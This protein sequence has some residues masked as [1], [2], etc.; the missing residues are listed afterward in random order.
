[1]K[2][3]FCNTPYKECDFPTSCEFTKKCTYSPLGV[4]LMEKKNGS[5]EFYKLLEDMAA[6]HNKKSHDYAMESNP[7]SNFERA[8]LIASWFTHPV[9]IAFAALIG[10]K[11]ARLAELSNGKTPNNESV[12]DTQLDLATYAALWGAWK[13]TK[14]DF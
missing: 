4:I 10:V 11:L 12:A 6:I 5:P 7:F 9:E 14:N 8:G 3:D 13:K 2:Y 1:M